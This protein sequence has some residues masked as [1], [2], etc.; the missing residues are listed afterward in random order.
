MLLG[1]FL[2]LPSS[3][4]SHRVKTRR[5]IIKYTVHQPLKYFVIIGFMTVILFLL[6]VLWQYWMLCHYAERLQLV[7]QQ[8]DSYIDA[9]KRTLKKQKGEPA[10]PEQ[11]KEGADEGVSDE[12][13]VAIDSFMV[14]NRTPQYLKEST[15]SY[16]KNQRLDSL[17]PRIDLHEWHDYNDEVATGRYQSTI[18]NKG[19]KRKRAAPSRISSASWRRLTKSKRA[20]LTGITFNLPIEQSKFWLSSFFGPRKKPSGE[21]GF[22]YGIDMAAQRGT[23][24]KAA[25][26]GIVDCAGYIAGYGNMVMLV[27]DKLYKTRYAHLDAINVKV[28]QQIKQGQKIG[29]VGDTGFTRKRGKDASHLHFELYERGKQIDPLYLLAFSPQQMT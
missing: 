26:S 27:H 15:V 10:V 11:Q 16:L 24:V 4:L 9:V 23:P 20:S 8:Y 14:I 5:S 21:W 22:H 7:I 3:L 18:K 6:L 29:S 19:I 1:G 17:I 2:P 13:E 28:G 12:D 25:A